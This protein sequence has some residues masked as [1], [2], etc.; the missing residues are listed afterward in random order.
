[1]LLGDH[2][3]AICDNNCSR[4][5]FVGKMLMRSNTHSDLYSSTSNKLSCTLT[6]CEFAVAQTD[7]RPSPDDTGQT[8][9]YRQNT[10]KC[11]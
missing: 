3:Q 2:K 7:V 9:S 4:F 10:L 6:G 11:Q 1:M 8:P 5:K